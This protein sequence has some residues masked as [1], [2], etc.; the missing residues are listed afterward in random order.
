MV[1]CS[2]SGRREAAEMAR[3]KV[4]FMALDYRI[5]GRLTTTCRTSGTVQ[6]A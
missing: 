3:S 4:L 2:S 5:P 1:S 6:I